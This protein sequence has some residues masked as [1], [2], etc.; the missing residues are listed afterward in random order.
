[1]KH[2]ILKKVSVRLPT[3]LV[4]ELTGPSYGQK[5][6]RACSEMRI[7]TC[8]QFSMTVWP[9]VGFGTYEACSN[10]ESYNPY[11]APRSV[12]GLVAL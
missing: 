4:L 10:G 9:L 8:Q 3:W 7:G 2:G 11:F 12:L 6:G 1:M 5:K